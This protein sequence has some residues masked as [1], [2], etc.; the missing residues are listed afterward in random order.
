MHRTLTITT[1]A[2]DPQLLTI[3][4]MRAAAGVADAS[5]DATL[6]AMGLQIAA[7]I[8]VECNIAIG[9]GS[10]PTLRRETVTE[11]LRGVRRDQFALRRRHDID[12]SSLVEDGVTLTEGVDF[13]VDSESGIVERLE[14][15]RPVPWCA[16]KVTIVY[17][18]GFDAV[19]SDLR[20]AA[21]EF[22]RASL[23]ASQRDPLVKGTETEIPGLHR[24]RTDYWVGSVPGQ[25]NE[26]AVP[27]AI[28][29]KLKRFRNGV[30][31]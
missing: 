1:P 24:R 17:V 25:S 20:H 30:V 18:A 10:V 15:D 4:E 9:G 21:T 2:N 26:G 7:D 29:G 27:D 13:L 19:P 6:T 8:A 16:E 3:E 28:D 31:G 23:L 14:C 5:Q 11:V 12:V 22:F